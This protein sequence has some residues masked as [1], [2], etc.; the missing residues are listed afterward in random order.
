MPVGERF[1]R[2]KSKKRIL[3][4]EDIVK[5]FTCILKDGNTDLPNIGRVL[6]LQINS[7]RIIFPIGKR[8]ELDPVSYQ[9]IMDMRF[10]GRNFIQEGSYDE[11]IIG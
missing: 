3:E 8:V 1:M 10:N 5:P 2:Y 11:L 6:Y 4:F 7:Q 9:H